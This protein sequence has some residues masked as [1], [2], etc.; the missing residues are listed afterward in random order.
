[1][2]KKSDEEN[3]ES[4]K[5]RVAKQTIFAESLVDSAVESDDLV[6]N[7]KDGPRTVRPVNLILEIVIAIGIIIFGFGVVDFVALFQ[8][9][10]LG[11]E[12]F[13]FWTYL[14][15]TIVFVGVLE[16]TRIRNA[17][18][19]FI[20][21]A[22]IISI[23]A[24]SIFSFPLWNAESCCEEYMTMLIFGFE[25]NAAITT[26]IV[27]ALTGVVLYLRYKKPFT[28]FL[29]ATHLASLLFLTIMLSEWKFNLFVIAIVGLVSVL[30]TLAYAVK[31]DLNES[32]RKSFEGEKT[33]W[34]Y[35]S[36][37]YQLLFLTGYFMM[38]LS[39][40]TGENSGWIVPSIWFD[41]LLIFALFG[42]ATN[43]RFLALGA[44]IGQVM[45]VFVI[46]DNFEMAQSA[47]GL[48]F[49][50][51]VLFGAF[52]WKPVRRLFLSFLP[53]EGEYENLFVSERS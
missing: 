9:K 8:E 33:F 15:S 47:T 32:D 7:T 44:L 36:A 35:M 51:V 17:N 16:I 1:M 14:I 41:V 23:S 30:A 24:G 31:R 45:S 19:P 6:V 3:G 26:C 2:S 39:E 42:L 25:D 22:T 38:Q 40:I 49:G 5:A 28:W 11:A 13:N 21:L 12:K 43:R 27:A 48:Y 29:I 52:G 18:V 50:I 53:N 4:K 20:V 46:F 37:A 34:L 10:V